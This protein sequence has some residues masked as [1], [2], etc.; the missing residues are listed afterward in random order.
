MNAQRDVARDR[1]WPATVEHV[2]DARHFVGETVARET[3]GAGDDDVRLITS[4]LVTN[5]VVHART[6]YTVSVA[7]T[8]MMVL[9]EVTDGSKEF[10]PLTLSGWWRSTFR[11]QHPSGHRGGFGLTLVQ[12]VALRWGWETT[13]VGKTVWA[14]LQARGGTRPATSGNG[15]DA[16][17]RSSTVLCEHAAH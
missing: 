9:I 5:A 2:R 7:C 11:R 1:R 4:E 8:G 16:A 13:R 10:G 12:A 6:P 3:I 14:I 17:A 15:S